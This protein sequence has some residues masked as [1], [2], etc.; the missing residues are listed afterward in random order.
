MPPPSHKPRL[1]TLILLT[2]M[3]VLTLNMFLPSLAH[4]AQDLETDYATVS[5]SVGGYLAMTAV[6]V[7]IIGPLSDRVG[8]RPVT[9][10]GLVLFTGAS[11]GC[12]LTDD[13]WLFLAFRMLQ[14]GMVA[15]YTLSITIVR[16]THPE[17]EAAAMIGRIGMAMALAPMLG[18]MLGGLL[19]TV[20]GWRATFW[21]YTIAGFGLLALCWFDLAETRPARQE[22]TGLRTGK[23]RQ[24]LGEPR[25]WAFALCTTFS[26]GAF[27]IFIAGA[28]IAAVTVFGSNTAEI[29][30]YVGSITGGFMLG[31]YGASRLAPHYPPVLMM[32]VGRIIAC[33]GLALGL[34]FVLA[35]WV[36]PL[37]FF[38]STF[39][40][41]LANGVTIP[42][43]SAAA[44]SVRPDLTGTAAGMEGALTVAGGAVLT[45]LTGLAVTGVNPHEAL[46][47]L[48]LAVSIAGLAAVLWA[49]RLGPAEPAASGA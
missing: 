21:F 44:M 4:I 22:P 1:L 33:A 49:M 41:G 34:A 14:G 45:T 13:I 6:I 37:L 38:G 19:D 40:A 35:G 12:A 31:A 27:Y 2:A 18:P 7:L 25:F 8:R 36:S 32:I 48:M 29:G 16:D 3:S 23:M 10:T 42:S 20:F 46:L 28:P 11:L 5:L 24:M 30:L 15:G 47:V 39:F 9:L 17:R 26:R 43:S